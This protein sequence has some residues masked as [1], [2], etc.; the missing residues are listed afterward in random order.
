MMSAPKVELPTTNVPVSRYTT[1]EYHPIIPT[2]DFQDQTLSLGFS[3]ETLPAQDPQDGGLMGFQVLKRMQ[4]FLHNIVNTSTD[5]R[6]QGQGMIDMNVSNK[7]NS[8][9]KNSVLCVLADFSSSMQ[10]AVLETYGNDCDGVAFRVRPCFE[11]MGAGGDCQGTNIDSSWKVVNMA[12]NQT[13]IYQ[14]GNGTASD[15]QDIFRFLLAF[16]DE[17]TWIHW[18]SPNRYVVPD[19]LRFLLRSSSVSID[20][21]RQPM[22]LESWNMDDPG[23]S[24]YTGLYGERQSGSCDHPRTF[25]Q[26][27]VRL[28]AHDCSALS[29]T[30]PVSTNL[31]TWIDSCLATHKPQCQRPFVR[32]FK[33]APWLYLQRYYEIQLAKN[34]TNNKSTSL[35]VSNAASLHRVHAIL[36]GIC[37]SIWDRP[38]GALNKDGTPGYI[39]DPT[40]LK[41]NLLPFTFHALGEKQAVCDIA[42]G[43]G[44]EGAAGYQGLRKIRIASDDALSATAT[45]TTGRTIRKRVLCMVY[46][47]SS[48]HDRLRAVA[49]TWGPRCDGFMAASDKT[50]ETIGAVHLL[51]EGPEHYSNMWLKVYAMWRYVYD[52]YRDDYDFFHIGEQKHQ[53]AVMDD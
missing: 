33:Q 21:R 10:N 48:R 42:P 3:C 43:E 39:H 35:D 49:E 25:N 4:F 50:D 8:Q 41:R 24:K 17:Y 37:D 23:Q 51:H 31:T 22:V 32:S 46:T 26:Q 2:D 20:D 15:F 14:S 28:L 38:L 36:H 40:F 27:T 47:H 13:K 19:F 1:I 11:R 44:E 6:K 53:E 7:S 18:A 5:T 9:Q 45:G 34:T 30:L 12:R 52:H 16:E 29:T